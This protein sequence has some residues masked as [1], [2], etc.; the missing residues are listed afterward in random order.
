MRTT[1]E[2]FG[3]PVDVDFNESISKLLKDS[4]KT[5]V[6]GLLLHD[7]ANS[8]DKVDLRKKVVAHLNIL[9]QKPFPHCGRDCLPEVLRDRAEKALR[10]Q[11][12]V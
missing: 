2:R 4:Y 8:H 5:M 10:Y 6:E 11:V 12:A 9:E 3:I 1:S 7:F